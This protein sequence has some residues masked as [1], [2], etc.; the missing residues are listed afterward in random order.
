MISKKGL[1]ISIASSIL[2][3]AALAGC[4]LPLNPLASSGVGQ[5]TP[6]PQQA[7]S[8]TPTL[9]SLPVVPAP[10]LQVLDMLDGQ[11]G[12]GLS[13]S[14]VLRTADGGATWQN[15]TPSGVTAVGLQASSFFLNASTGWVLLP[16]PDYSP[17][18][19]YHTTDGGADWTASSFPYG[20]ALL[21]FRDP[22]DGTAL[23]PLG[24]GAG[25]EAVAVEGT[26]DA[27]ATWTQ[28]FINDP[29]VTG[30]SASLPLGG[31][32]SGLT[33]LDAS[34]GWV[35][36]AEPMDDFIYLFATRDGGHTW[37]HQE[38]GMPSGISGVQAAAEA[39]QFFGDRDGVLPVSLFSDSPAM[40]FYLSHDGGNTWTPTTPVSTSGHYAIA[41]AS[42]FFVWDGGPSLQVSHDSGASW[43]SVSP[44][45]SVKEGLVSFQFVNAATG[46]ALITGAG[47][48][49]SLY[50]TADGGTTWIA[51]IP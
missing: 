42:D 16:G 2:L 5:A 6:E 46:W 40:V 30:S 38:L 3:L 20:G 36:G 28:V 15:A 29:T 8:A 51:L 50:K 26:A 47:G 13:D 45:I 11:D 27:G 24:A 31:Q 33:F 32:K 7:A 25:S 39:V 1:R 22:A 41:S 17:G 44:N 43:S 23:I 14:A 12:W 35:A 9:A 4:N 19:L 34:R 10:D 21:Q 18:T 48:A 49:Y 37:A